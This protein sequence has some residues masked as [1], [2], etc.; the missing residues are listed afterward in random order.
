MLKSKASELDL[1]WTSPVGM[2]FSWQ[3]VMLQWWFASWNLNTPQREMK[4]II[5]LH[6]IFFHLFSLWNSHAF[7]SICTRLSHPPS[8][9]TTTSHNSLTLGGE[10]QTFFSAFRYKYFLSFT[11]WCV[12]KKREST[13]CSRTEKSKG[14]KK[15]V[16]NSLP[17][18]QKKKKLDV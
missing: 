8:L 7:I 2:C 3:T 10:A 1:Q 16:K 11:I 14:E 18:S 12:W 4:S 6:N 15:T 9:T 17:R 5:N 13:P